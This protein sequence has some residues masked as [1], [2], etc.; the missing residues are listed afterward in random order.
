[1][2]FYNDVTVNALYVRT[3]IGI[4]PTRKKITKTGKT[5][6]VFDDLI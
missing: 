3:M 1:M 6:L 5:I 2:N 4:Y